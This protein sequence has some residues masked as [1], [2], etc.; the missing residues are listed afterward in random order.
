VPT[1]EVALSAQIPQA[2]LFHRAQP[3]SLEGP[4]EAWEL[5]EHV[6]NFGCALFSATSTSRPERQVRD[7]VFAALIRRATVTTEGVVRLLAAGL[8]EP[9]M[10]ITRTLLDIDVSIK[11]VAADGTDRMAK[12]LAACH[13][14]LM[15]QHGQ[16]M[17]ADP[18]TRTQSLESSGRIAEV[19]GIARS[20]KRLLQGG[21]LAEVEDEVRSDQYWHGHKNVEEAFRATGQSSD[22]HMTYDTGTWFV[23]AA[24][25]EHDLIDRSDAGVTVRAFVE[26]DPRIIQTLLGYA[27]LRYL[28]VVGVFIKERGLPD[29]EHFRAMSDVIFPDGKVT[30]I[31]SFTALSMRVSKYFHPPEQ[32]SPAALAP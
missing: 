19:Q 31:D 1:F 17:L 25:I 8:Q 24:N 28:M 30:K 22:Y 27:L 20:Y 3:A 16:D 26:R 32:V 7:L 11:L 23:H 15:Q 2:D 6:V 13:Y 21:V 5:A 12:R 10:A 9:A 29:T 18:M 4:A 14:I